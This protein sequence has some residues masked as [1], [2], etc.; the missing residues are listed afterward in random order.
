M[1]RIESYY[2]KYTDDVVVKDRAHLF[3]DL[4]NKILHKD[5]KW[6]FFYEGIYD[7]LRFHSKFRRR[8]DKFLD[9]DNRIKNY[10]QK[11]EGWVD[12]HKIVEEYK[13]YFTEIFHQNS[14]MAIELADKI[15]FADDLHLQ[16]IIDRVVHSFFNMIY[17]HFGRPT[18]EVD[19]MKDY[20]VDRAFYTGMMWQT[21]KEK[22][23]E[24]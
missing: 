19:V 24:E 11:A 8:V 3:E 7:E 4:Y 16:L 18:L 20:L 9:K 23:N 2:L 5:D 15:D 13:D 12:N 21:L 22:N 10:T 17:P 14:L 6:H 1:G